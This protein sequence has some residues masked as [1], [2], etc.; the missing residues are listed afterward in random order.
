MKPNPDIEGA[1]HAVRQSFDEGI[2]RRGGGTQDAAAPDANIG[3]EIPGK[4]TLHPAIAALASA[5]DLEDLLLV[6]AWNGSAAGLCSGP[7]GMDGPM[8]HD[9]HSITTITLSY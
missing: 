3:E 9:L 8:E 2:A 4:E 5:E 7:V 6:D 1:I